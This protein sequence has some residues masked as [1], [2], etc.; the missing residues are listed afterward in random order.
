MFVSSLI[1]LVLLSQNY[2]H[3]KPAPSAILYRHQIPR[4]NSTE[5]WHALN[6]TSK[7]RIRKSDV[8]VKRKPKFMW[9]LITSTVAQN[10]DNVPPA[11]RAPMMFMMGFTRQNVQ[12]FTSTVQNIMQMI[13]NAL[14]VMAVKQYFFSDL[15]QP[16]RQK[17]SGISDNV[18]S[19]LNVI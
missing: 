17:A 4:K 13:V 6:S 10:M 3:A 9:D 11:M 18:I 1:V 8:D 19:I 15:S 5:G 14:V 16:D 2:V 12:N 7:T